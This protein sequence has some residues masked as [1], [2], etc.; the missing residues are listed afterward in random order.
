MN[1]TDEPLSG[2]MIKREY[3]CDILDNKKIVGF[4]KMNVLDVREPDR[5]KDFTQWS[6]WCNSKT[7]LTL[8]AGFGITQKTNSNC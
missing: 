1:Q 5:C 6:M 8:R 3:L 4:N 7:Q 2:D